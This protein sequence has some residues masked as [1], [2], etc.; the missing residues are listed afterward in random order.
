[1][2]EWSVVARYFEGTAV[3][4]LATLDDDGSPHVVPLWI[5]RHGEADLVFF[6]IAGTRKDR[7][8][9]R[10]PRVAVSITRP[11]SA[12]DMATVKGDVV[13]RVDGSA[14][15]TLVD[16]IAK[17]YTGQEYDVRDGLVAFVFRPKSWVSHDYSGD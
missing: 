10:D 2:Q 13:E 15:M 7:N 3:A 6:T 8:V 11:E 14:G 12:L 5:E 17:A 9:T 4:H 1:M 16:R